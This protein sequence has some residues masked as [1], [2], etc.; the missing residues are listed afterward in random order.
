MCKAFSGIIKDNGEVLWEF[1]M[2]SHEDIIQKWGLKDDG[3]EK[4]FARFEIAPAN[5]SY[6]E[7]DEWKFRVDENS[8][9]KWLNAGY[10]KFCWGAKDE[11]KKKLDKILIHKPI[12]H[13]FKDIEPPKTITKAH[14][15]LLKKWVSAWASVW[16]YVGSFFQLP[17]KSWKYTKKIKT[18]G[19]PFQPAVELWEMGLVPSFDG[20]LWRLHGG[21]DAKILWEGKLK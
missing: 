14:L 10:E 4:T 17:R 21:P 2:D 7:P 11:W 13:P 19:Y 5:G 15:A 9:P 12:V 18:K 8:R 1:G 16:A 6:L 20:K 3:R